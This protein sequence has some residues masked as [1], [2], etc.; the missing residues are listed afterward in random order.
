MDSPFTRA[1]HNEIVKRMEDEHTRINQRV[2]E[3]E[4]V[5]K[6]INDLT[7]SISE[8]ST[9]MKQ[10][11]EELR[12]QGG[13]LEELESRDGEMWRKVVGHVITCVAGI[14]NSYLFF[15]IGM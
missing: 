1:K 8:M 13:R 2:A 14:V 10:M 9:S 5:V 4:T 11:I 6:K 3:L 15:Q 7:I 12:N